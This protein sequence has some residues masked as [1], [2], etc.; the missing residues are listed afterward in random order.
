MFARNSECATPAQNTSLGELRKVLLASP[1]E[2]EL[3]YEAYK[4]LKNTLG[5][6]LSR[7]YPFD[8]VELAA[9]VRGKYNIRYR[10]FLLA[11]EFMPIY[12]ELIPKIVYGVCQHPDDLTA[13]VALYW[14]KNSARRLPPCL[15]KGLA[16]AFTR[17]TADDLAEHN[18]DSPVKLKDVLFLCRAKPGNGGQELAF[19]RLRMDAL[20][21]PGTRKGP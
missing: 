3:A 11:L 16:K 15:R 7:C 12:P 14:K 18:R 19:A 10:S 20:P 17:F 8:V 6:L 9:E 5:E 2:D 13:I 4:S 1:S 21:L